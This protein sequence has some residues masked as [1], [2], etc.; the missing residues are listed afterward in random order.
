MSQSRPLRL[1]VEPTTDPDEMKITASRGLESA[2]ENFDSPQGAAGH[3]LAGALFRIG[4]VQRVYLLGNFIRIRKEP[5]ADW[6][7]IG[8]AIQTRI[9]EVL[10]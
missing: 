10:G 2:G 9:H 6:R 3:P 1:T 7:Q 8:P 4:G 5:Q